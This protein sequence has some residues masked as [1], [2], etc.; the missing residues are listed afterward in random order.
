MAGS[1][2]WVVVAGAALGPLACSSGGNNGTGSGSGT[3]TFSCTI[4]GTQCTQIVGPP[5]SQSGEQ[6]SCNQQQG[7]FATTP[8]PTANATACCDNMPGGISQCYYDSNPND[9]STYASLC[10]KQG[11]TWVPAEGGVG[12]GGAA[13][14]VGTWART[15]TQTVTCPGSSPT[16]TNISGNLVISLGTTAT[17]IVGTQPDGCVTNYS[18][19][20][21]VATAASGQTGN[22]SPGGVAETVTVNSHTLTLSSDGTTI[23]SNGTDTILKTATN[24]TCNGTNSGTYTKQ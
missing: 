11:G 14:F 22:V 3:M 19:S 4:G 23:T 17:G 15:G 16:T 7:T 13:A 10:S 5:S 1:R 6:S 8:C 2:L 24:T 12:S 20:G 21:N 9:L 18:V